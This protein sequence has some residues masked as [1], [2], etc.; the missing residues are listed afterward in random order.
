MNN[1]SDTNDSINTWKDEYGVV[2]SLNRKRL[3]RANPSLGLVSYN[4]LDGTEIIEEH[5]FDFCHSLNEIDLPESLSV[6]GSFAFIG[7]HSLKTIRIPQSLKVIRQGAFEECTSLNNLFIPNNTIFE[8]AQ[9]TFRRCISLQNICYLLFV[10][11]EYQLI[12]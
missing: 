2:Y 7:C 6:I 5:A 9:D 4:I 8:I 3:I 12:R 11:M 1:M 10:Q